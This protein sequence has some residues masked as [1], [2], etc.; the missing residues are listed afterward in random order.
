MNTD[1]LLRTLATRAATNIQFVW[2]VYIPH[3]ANRSQ[4]KTF[5]VAS[6]LLKFAGKLSQ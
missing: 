2:K 4:W 5:A 6:I 1:S 3:N